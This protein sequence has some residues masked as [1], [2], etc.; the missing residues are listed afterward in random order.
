MSELKNLAAPFHHWKPR[1]FVGLIMIILAF[2]GLIITEIKQDGAW[3]YWRVLCVIFAVLS[4]SLHIF[5]RK[6]EMVT[7]FGTIW[8]EVLHWLGLF[9]CVTIISVMVEVGFLARFVSS[10]TVL[11]LLALT[12]YLAGIYMEVTLVFVGIMLGLFTLGLS[13]VSAYLYPALIPLSLLAM[14][15]LW[16]YLKRKH[17]HHKTKNED[18]P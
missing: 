14:I 1:L 3:E 6:R 4:I 18:A 15:A 7:Y 17:S 10:I 11:M 12:T 8:H 5:L 13:V 2:L 9:L 16:I